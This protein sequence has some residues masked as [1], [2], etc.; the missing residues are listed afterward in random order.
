MVGKKKIS[1]F[2]KDEKLSLIEK[3]NT[4]LLCSNE[5]IVWV[6]GMRMDDRFKVTNETQTILKI[7]VEQ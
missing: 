2:F 1:K 5:Q 7:T 4:W 6:I 3:N